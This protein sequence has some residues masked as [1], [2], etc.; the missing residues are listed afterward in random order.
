LIFYANC[1]IKKRPLTINITKEIGMIPAKFFI[2]STLVR[3]ARIPLWYSL[4]PLQHPPG[5]EV[6]LHQETWNQAGSTLRKYPRHF[7]LVSKENDW[8]TITFP[9]PKSD[10][11]AQKNQQSILADFFREIDRVLEKETH[12]DHFQL[13][14]CGT[15]LSK[16]SGL[17]S[18]L[19]NVYVSYDLKQLLRKPEGIEAAE[20]AT[21]T[22]RVAA[23][24]FDFPVAPGN[25]IASAPDGFLHFALRDGSGSILAAD[26]RD[27]EE[28]DYPFGYTMTSDNIDCPNLQLIFLSALT[29][30][31]EWGRKQSS[32]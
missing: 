23:A 31:A 6:M 7:R 16:G 26:Y 2:A 25:F 22:M 13:V 24:H 29:A 8:V 14:A 5:I 11:Y 9:F 27:R 28:P 30:V 12:P 10:P 1:A 19:M 20:I 4:R 21:Q 18:Y 32:V 3:K 15:L 17:K